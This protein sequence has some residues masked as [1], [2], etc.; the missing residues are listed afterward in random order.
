[1]N[2]NVSS[3][4]VKITI[5]STITKELHELGHNSVNKNYEAFAKWIIGDIEYGINAEGETPEAAYV[6]LR[7]KLRKRGLAITRANIVKSED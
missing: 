6:A 7:N 2:Y 4:S 3:D 1:M 5:G